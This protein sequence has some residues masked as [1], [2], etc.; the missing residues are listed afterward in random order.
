[1]KVRIKI[2]VRLVDGTYPFLDPVLSANG[3][4]KPLYAIVDG[5]AEHH[6]EGSYFLRYADGSGKRIWERVGNDSQLTLTTKQRRERGE[7]QP[8]D[9]KTDAG[10]LDLAECIE[11]YLLEV[12]QA[13][14]KRTYQA[15]SLTLNS[16]AKTTTKKYL[17]AIDR[18]DVLVFLQS[19]RDAKCAPSRIASRT[20][21]AF[22]NGSI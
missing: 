3:K 15:Y 18:K 21:D 20:Y 12:K 5:Q 1:M 9:V 4:L 2:R 16:F 14:A 17:D 10:K 11:E 13:N 22:P 19:L 7:K 8:D 6:P